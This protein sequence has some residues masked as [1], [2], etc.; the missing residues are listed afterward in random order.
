[1]EQV[2]D[3][4]IRD[5]CL[6]V[7]KV[8]NRN[9]NNGYF[10]NKKSDQSVE[11]K[12]L[13]GIRERKRSRNCFDSS[14]DDQDLEYSE[15]NKKP[16]NICNARQKVAKVTSP[17]PAEFK[18]EIQEMGGT[19]IKLIIQKNLF[20][21]DTDSGQNRFS[22]PMKQIR[23]KFLNDKEESIL[24]QRFKDMHV[25]PLMVPLIEPNLEKT[26]INFRKWETNSSYV[27][28]KPWNGIRDRNGLKPKMEMQLLSF[29][30]DGELNLALVK[31]SD[32]E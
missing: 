17:L 4:E 19:D 15:K 23:E 27:L 1:M 10:L 26:Q 11:E 21:T 30:V 18:N 22:I 6:G 5:D 16:R 24:D 28:S 32:G 25:V 2:E 12:L 31:V 9:D 29:R 14:E 20:S 3:K 13:G 7:K 8:V